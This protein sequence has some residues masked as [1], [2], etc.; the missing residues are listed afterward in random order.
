MKVWRNKVQPVPS[1]RNLDT[2]AAINHIARL[3]DDLAAEFLEG[4]KKPLITVPV[5]ESTEVHGVQRFQE[6]FDLIEIVADYNALREAI[7]EF[8]EANRLMITGRVRA[9]MD[10]VLDKAIG[11]AVQTYSKQKALEIE[12]QREEHL[13]FIIH[14]LK[15]PLS[16][17]STAAM[18]LRNTFSEERKDERV[19]RM[20]EIVQRNTIRLNSLIARVIEE[21]KLL[22]HAGA[23]S[24]FA[25]KVKKRQLDLWPLVEELI[26]D[27]QALM[28][29]KGIHARNQVPHDCSIFADPVLIMHVFQNLLSNAIEY[30]RH[31]EIM[32]GAAASEANRLV[33]CWVLD[34]GS[35]IPQERIEK[36]FD[37]LETD[38]EER[39]G[40]GLGLAIAKQVV[41][42]HGGQIWV[43]SMLDQGS[44]FEFTLPFE[45]AADSASSRSTGGTA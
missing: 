10:R 24:V 30:T 40:L 21:Q 17:V 34:T 37:K 35:G 8:A 19:R 1:T 45:G 13:S 39:G 18:I 6:G 32:I 42:T 22:Q 2:P 36:V 3:L 23:Q 20:L 38:R 12:R 5:G 26:H 11:V 15:T 27:F 43:K 9:I 41:E 4:K 16:A 25:A 14:D 44:T 33:R 28:E 31:G 29:P 7:Q